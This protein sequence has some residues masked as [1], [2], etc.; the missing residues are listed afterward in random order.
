MVPETQ[1]QISAPTQRDAKKYI[2]TCTKSSRQNKKRKSGTG[3]RIPCN[4]SA[5]RVQEDR[6]KGDL[7]AS[8]SYKEALLVMTFK[9]SSTVSIG[10]TMTFNGPLMDL[11]PSLCSK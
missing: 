8:S 9:A 3:T 6:S 7:S 5:D 11:I 10:V 1:D 4:N 2:E